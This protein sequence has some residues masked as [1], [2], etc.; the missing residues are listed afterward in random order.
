MHIDVK[1]VREVTVVELGGE[2]V[3]TVVAEAEER[4]LAVAGPECKFVLDL[5]HL[6]YLGSAGLRLLLSVFRTVSD[7]GGRVLLVG[8]TPN[9]KDIM[10]ATGFLAFFPHCDDLETGLS[11]LSS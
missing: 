3:W 8:L 10:K 4:I 9:I 6:S 1:T 5:S 2:L 11:V 7:Q